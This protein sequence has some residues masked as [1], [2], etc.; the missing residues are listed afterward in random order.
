MIKIRNT[1]LLFFCIL[2]KLNS[3]VNQSNLFHNFISFI[4]FSVLLVNMW[5]LEFLWHQQIYA[6]NNICSLYY[7]FFNMDRAMFM[8]NR[9]KTM[10]T[11]VKSISMS[12]LRISLIFSKSKEFWRWSFLWYALQDT[13]QMLSSSSHR[14]HN[15]M[16]SLKYTHW[17]VW[18]ILDWH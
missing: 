12:R 18:Y 7:N 9:I 8:L 10:H 15:S 2:W 14:Q 1:L 4:L 5:F 11:N 16:W 13:L 3:Y 17:T 6:Q